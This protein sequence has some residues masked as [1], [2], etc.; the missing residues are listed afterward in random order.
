MADAHKYAATLDRTRVIHRQELA[1]QPDPERV[2][3]GSDPVRLG[4]NFLAIP[5]PGHTCGHCALLYK[6]RFLFTGDHLWWSRM[7]ELLSAYE[8]VCG[9]SWPEQ[10]ES[11][12]WVKNYRFE[13]VLPGRGQRAKLSQEV[14]RERLATLVARLRRGEDLT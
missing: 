6:D 14:M 1:S 2:M 9:Y 10:I 3:E 8:E 7:R 11:L 4:P 12:A 5:T 13:W